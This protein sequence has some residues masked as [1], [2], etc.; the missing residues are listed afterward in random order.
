MGNKWFVDGMEVTTKLEE[1]LVKGFIDLKGRIE[2]LEARDG[3]FRELH[4]AA[5]D[6]TDAA[7]LALDEL[8]KCNPGFARV[9][10]DNL[11][12]QI[13]TTRAAL[14]GKDELEALRERM[15]ERLR[16]PKDSRIDALVKAVRELSDAIERGDAIGGHEAH[17]YVLAALKPFEG[18]S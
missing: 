15:T 6:I 16:P 17:G 4:Q 18:Q 10:R 8:D 14:E 5:A 12:A 1:A 9:V 11:R 13:P 2:A 7:E 3:R